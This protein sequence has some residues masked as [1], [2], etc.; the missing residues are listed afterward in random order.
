MVRLLSAGSVA[1]SSW[2]EARGCYRHSEV[3]VVGFKGKTE[4]DAVVDFLK[5]IDFFVILE[6]VAN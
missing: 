4:Q 6:F 3:T 1:A 5:K 2:A